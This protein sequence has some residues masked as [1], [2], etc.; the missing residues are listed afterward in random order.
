[1]EYTV[2]NNKIYI[3]TPY[4]DTVQILNSGQV[5]RWEILNDERFI[6]MSKDKLCILSEEDG[7]PVIQTD[8]LEYFINYFDLDTDYS[9]VFNK[10]KSFGGITEQAAIFGRGIRILRQDEEETIFSFIISANNNIKR[11]QGIIK[12]ICD[13]LGNEKDFQG[14]KYKSFPD[15]EKLAS[16]GKD[17][18]LSIGAGYR[19]SYLAKTSQ[20]IAGGFDIKSIYELNAQD[21]EKKLMQLYGVGKKVAD[22]ILLFGYNR[23]DVFPTDTWIEKVYIDYFAKD[24]NVVPDR[25]KISQ[26]LVEI[27]G[28]FSGYAQQ[29]LFFYKRE[30]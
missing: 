19:A 1:M 18:Y 26:N 12:R 7:K 17:F 23:Q 21:A 2:K 5:F 29:Y 9:Y 20:M 24:K 11:I 6:L 13:N 25:A 3:D 15:S 4:F 16:A 22:C 28:D 14:I 27:F 30:L 8:D 10:I